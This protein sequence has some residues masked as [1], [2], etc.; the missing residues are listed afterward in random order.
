VKIFLK[1]EETFSDQFEELAEKIQEGTNLLLE[2]LDRYE[3]AGEK[4]PKLKDIEREADVITHRV[5][6]KLHKTFITPLDR[7]DIYALANKLDSILDLVEEAGAKMSLYKIKGP[8]P[9]IRELAQILSKA[10]F[11]IRKIIYD[12]RHHSKNFKVIMDACVEINTLE[13]EGDQILRKSMVQLF[14]RED[15]VIELV[16][17]K[18]ILELVEEATDICEDISNVI[19]GILLKHG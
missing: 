4:I 12:M 18:E 3:H 10:V 11:L 13:N 6:N 14:E 2:I 9:E 7:E 5:Y 1:K 16:K 8:I 17:W 19:E 15:D